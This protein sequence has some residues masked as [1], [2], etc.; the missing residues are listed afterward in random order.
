MY[1]VTK[2]PGTHVPICLIDS[3]LIKGE[4]KVQ[5]R[6]DYHISKKSSLGFITKQVYTAKQ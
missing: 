4:N 1:D 6:F 5:I 2:H 3:T